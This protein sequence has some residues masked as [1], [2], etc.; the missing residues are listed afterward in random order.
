[1][2][3]CREARPDRRSRSE[4]IPCEVERLPNR[5]DIA[6]RQ[7]AASA[8]AIYGAFMSA[9]DYGSWLPPKGMTAAVDIYE[10]RVGGAYRV[11]LTYEAPAKGVRGKTSGRTDVARGRFLELVPNERIVQSAVFES[12]DV[13]FAGTMKI[14]WTFEQMPRG[15][16]VTV[17]ASDVPAG[18][19]KNDHQAGLASSLANLAAFVERRG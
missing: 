6:S 12:D 9:E 16:R 3:G 19:E 5:T 1:M 10:P 17:V 18:I 2:P 14:S 13:R 4:H 7:I 11:T 8:E 15:T